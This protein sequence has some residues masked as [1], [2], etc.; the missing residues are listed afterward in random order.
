MGQ[1]AGRAA[2]SPGLFDP[3]EHGAA[4]AC[5]GAGTPTGRA[6]ASSSTCNRNSW[7]TAGLLGVR[8]SGPAP[9]PRRTECPPHHE[10]HHPSRRRAAPRLARRPRRRDADPALHARSGDG[11][12]VRL[13]T[14]FAIAGMGMEPE[15][16]GAQSRRLGVPRARARGCRDR[17]PR[18]AARR[19]CG[20]GA[21]AAVLAA[22][23][24]AVAPPHRT[25]HRLD[26]LV[27]VA[28]ARDIARFA[29][30]APVAP[31]ALQREPHS[32]AGAAPL[33]ARTTAWRGAGSPPTSSSTATPRCSARCASPSTT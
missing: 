28:R 9:R 4:G 13:D 3:P 22:L 10:Q 11:V 12:D 26:R 5:A 16:I 15:R 24:L 33:T 30:P 21:G 32:T 14:T 7:P 8:R 27:A 1:P 18:H 23:D 20:A 17:R 29:D 19:R 25:A 31:P 6:Y 2:T